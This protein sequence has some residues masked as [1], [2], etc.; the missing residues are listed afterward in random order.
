MKS[1]EAGEEFFTL[2]SNLSG[3]LEKLVSLSAPQPKRVQAGAVFFS[4]AQCVNQRAVFSKR[5]QIST[6]LAL[7]KEAIEEA[8]CAFHARMERRDV[9]YSPC[10]QEN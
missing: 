4:S 8:K 6:N 9:A 7:L 5:T 1:K 3:N 2:L 10:S